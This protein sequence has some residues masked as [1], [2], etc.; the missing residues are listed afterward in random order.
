MASATPTAGASLGTSNLSFFISTV[1]IIGILLV[2]LYLV[3]KF[4][5]KHMKSKYMKIIDA[6]P[7]GKSTIVYLIQLK[8]RYL[9]IACTPSDTKVLSELDDP[10][11]IKEIEIDESGAQFSKVLFSKLGKRFLKDQIDRIDELK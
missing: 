7:L 10:E 5:V 6:L 11:E 3:K 4:G 8:S 9:F 1:I 2:V